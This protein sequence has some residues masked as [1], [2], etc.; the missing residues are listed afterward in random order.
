VS[1]LDAVNVTMTFEGITALDHVSLDV[2][3]GELVGLIGPNGAGKT[4]FF[5]CL[6]G[7][8]RPD[9]GR[10]RFAGHDLTR[11]PTHRR[12][13]LGIGRTFQRIELFSGMSPREHLLVA[14]RARTAHGGL[15]KD[16]IR[17]GGPTRSEQER[18]AT[19]L[20]LLGLDA[21][22]DRK[23]ESLSLGVG[24]LVEVGRAL[25]IDPRLLLLDEPSS[26]LDRE[27]TEQL[28]R[29]LLDVQRERGTAILLVEHDVDLVRSF[30]ARVFVLDFGTV[31]A[32][33]R[34]EDVFADAAVRRAYLGDIV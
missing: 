32:S 2:D 25:M 7:L 5:N 16:A 8:L 34:T 26:G 15:L 10:V 19:V 9:E 29:S 30:V 28:A 11:V 3:E 33:G 22:A 12:A 31:I 27:E 6:L 18:A 1:L 23:V 13:R 21:V 14:D 17:R 24:R 4:T 20:Q